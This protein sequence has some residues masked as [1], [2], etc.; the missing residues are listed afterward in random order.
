M[1][2]TIK[3]DYLTVSVDSFGAQ[4]C[5]VKSADG[6]EYM[7]QG[8]KYW[9]DHCPVLFPTCG[10]LPG[11]KY[12]VGDKEYKLPIHGIVMYREAELAEASDTRLVFRFTSCEETLAN[13]PFRFELYVVFEISGNTLTTKIIPKNIGDR[14]MPYMVGWHPGFNLWGDG[15]IGEFRVDFGKCDALPWY[16]IEPG[17][18]IS[19]LSRPHE[20]TDDSYYLCEEEIYYN[21]TMIFTD[22]VLES[23]DYI[24]P[25]AEHGA[26]AFYID[27]S[28]LTQ[29]HLISAL[30]LYRAILLDQT[31]PGEKEAWRTAHPECTEGYYG[32]KTIL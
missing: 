20:L 30:R 11:R 25:L 13:Y 8:E 29:E 17:H 24:K 27:G 9:E 31:A 12:F 7:W 28:F 16:P 5:S 21:D 4:M 6:Y 1:L 14:V 3:N 32:Q 18:P 2:Y 22:Y 26:S 19:K 15:D 23:F 10:N